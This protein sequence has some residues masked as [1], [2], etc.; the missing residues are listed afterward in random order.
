MFRVILAAVLLLL[1]QSNFLFS[2]TVNINGNTIE[3]HIDNIADFITNDNIIFHNKFPQLNIERTDDFSMPLLSFN[4]AAPADTE[5][6]IELSI[7]QKIEYYQSKIE[8]NRKIRDNRKIE[9]SNELLGTRR[10]AN[11]YRITFVP[12]EF[13]N[14]QMFIADDVTIKITMPN[15]IPKTHR[16]DIPDRILSF[17][18]DVVN[19]SQVPSIIENRKN[20]VSTDNTLSANIWYDNNIDYIRVVTKKDGIARIEISELLAIYPDWNGLSTNGLHLI[21][22]GN[23]VPI[24]VK[25]SNNQIE[26]SGQIYFLGKRAAG[27]TTW[28]DNYTDEAVFFLYYDS[29]KTPTRLEPMF[30]PATNN[31][32]ETVDID[33]HLEEDLSYFLGTVTIF[34]RTDHLEGWYFATIRR[35]K[36]NWEAQLEQFQRNFPFLSADNELL[37]IQM[38]YATLAY[39][40]H[41]GPNLVD[42]QQEYLYN[43]IINDDTLSTTKI[44]R[45]T[46]SYSG[47]KRFGNELHKGSNRIRVIN[48]VVHDS[49]F[50]LLGIDYFKLRGKAKP[51]PVNG[52][53]QFNMNKLV[54]ESRVNIHG[55][56]A[57]S[58][59]GIDTL[60][61]RFIEKNGIEGFRFT[62]SAG[63]A[64][65]SS[66]V[67]TINDTIS[68]QNASGILIGR[69]EPNKPA[70][71]SYYK[72]SAEADRIITDLNALPNGSLI[73]IACNSIFSLSYQ[74]R[75]QFAQLGA[76]EVQN[77]SSRN[78][79]VFAVKKGSSDKSEKLLTQNISGI[80]GFF[81]QSGGGSYSIAISFEQ[82]KDYVLY[83]NDS[84]A[85]EKAILSKVAKSNLRRTDLGADLIVI[86]H[87]KF[88]EPAK[89]IAEYRSEQGYRVQLAIV[90][91]IYKEFLYGRKSPHSIKEYLKF[92][93]NNWELPKPQYLLI[94]GDASW[95]GRKVIPSTRGEN[96]VPSFGQPVSDYWFGLLEGDDWEPEMI[97]GR[98]PAQQVEQ[99]Y[100]YFDKVK[101]YESI[102]TMQWM[103]RFLF[104]SGGITDMEME[105]FYGDR[106]DFFDPIMD[107]PLCADTATIAKSK[108]NAGGEEDMPRILSAINSGALWTCFLG[109]SSTQVFDM[110][111]WH[112]EYLNN[113]DR[114]GFLS[115]LSCN[116]GAFAEPLDLHSRN[117]KYILEKEK[118]FVAALGSTGVGFW[119]QDK[120]MIYFMMSTVGD[121]SLALRRAG[122]ILYYGKSRLSINNDRELVTKEIFQLLGDPVIKLRLGIEPDLFLV[123]NDLKLI[124]SSGDLLPNEN[125]DYIDIVGFLHNNGYAANDSLYLRLIHTYNGISDTLFLH[126]PSICTLEEFSFKL[127][128]FQKPG[129]HAV[130]LLAD[131]DFFDDA[132]F[133]DNSIQRTFYVYSSNLLS[134]DP[135]NHWN[136]SPNNPIFRFINPLN[137]EYEFEYI[138]NLYQIIHSNTILV[139]ESNN[140]EIKRYSTH[141]DWLPNVIL[142]DNSTYLI[143]AK[144]INTTLSTESNYSS[145][146]VHTTQKLDT[147]VIYRLDSYS[148]LSSIDLDGLKV[149]YD[150]T[151]RISETMIDFSLL[152]VNGHPKGEFL[153]WSNISLSD[154]VYL[155]HQYHRGFNIVVVPMAGENPKG[156]YRRYDTWG[157]PGDAGTS[158]A[159]VRFLRDTVRSDEYILVATSGQSYKMPTDLPNTHTGSIDSLRNVFKLYGA[160]LSDSLGYNKSYV[161]AGFKG[162][163]ESE[164]FEQINN[165][166][167][168]YVAGQLRFYGTSGKASTKLIGPAKNWNDIEV[169]GLSNNNF[170]YNIITHFI[171]PTTG[172]V[173]SQTID[174]FGNIPVENI[175]AKD[176]PFAQLEVGMSR[177]DIFADNGIYRISFKFQPAPELAIIPNST[178]A[179]PSEVLRG[180]NIVIETEVINLSL[181]TSLDTALI[182]Q[183]FID[184]SSHSN[185]LHSIITGIAANSS[186][187]FNNSI[188]SSN[189]QKTVSANVEV[190][191]NTYEQYVFNNDGSTSFRIIE[192]TTKPTAVVLIDRREIKDGYYISSTPEIEVILFDNSRLPIFD[193]RSISIRLN[194]LM[195]NAT[196]A[197]SYKFESFGTNTLE[198]ARLIVRPDTIIETDNSLFVYY[199]DASLN[200]DTLR[201]LL[202]ISRNGKIS[203]HRIAPNPMYDAAQFII[204]LEMP[205]SEGTLLIDIYN[206]TGMK[207]NSIKQNAKLGENRLLW[208]GRSADGNSLPQ[209]IYFYRIRIE[210]TIFFDPTV[211]NL[212]IIK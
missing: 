145:T 183:E 100:N 111:G 140:N 178:L 121:K 30:E 206:S 126:Y 5:L 168:A 58:I 26:S 148:E 24:Y 17:F 150:G 155:D 128:I 76:S 22:R 69:K 202:K 181:R 62:A 4:L 196:N 127:P 38:R 29:N 124:P 65:D 52:Q 119:Q 152:S 73:V 41:Q 112:V 136:I 18:G 10:G 131:S 15:A 122:D 3:I 194:G 129:E 134:I 138:F 139:K 50:G 46:Y 189:F 39:A 197:N 205:R 146:I 144:S 193:E 107:Y 187:L 40:H 92:A 204:N 182:T 102:P 82:N 25:S 179:N 166:D 13:I 117:E 91:D 101:S 7:K 120:W 93:Y 172:E 186:M 90:E 175:S 109:H 154:D 85:I 54:A 53:V 36:H 185:K 200:R 9:V 59:I 14:N 208:N 20:K 67:V 31:L 72:S 81:N 210:D 48:R 108:A 115:T 80:D 63:A 88:I 79:W 191:S 174:K 104:L 43:F 33:Y 105:L 86:A 135:Q 212:I 11:I 147:N 49:V 130:R 77:Y 34:P 60:S 95:D 201:F 177:E 45:W 75:N 61:N 35:I 55:F 153:E 28:W 157:E 37:D 97:V 173:H 57:N 199:Y 142:V 165:F 21:E 159:L 47:G 163:K 149:F 116:T 6:Q 66:L 32:I 161:F 211:G 89:E 98:I 78:G 23:D 74:L 162:A 83:F 99:V 203:N 1:T 195:L 19:L 94:I 167:T 71:F 51:F 113:K 87:S 184:L 110:D 156:T 27:D 137:E 143:N 169:I 8:N 180:N 171:N 106:F 151:L 70:I 133:A 160:L 16:R 12:A 64:R 192:D 68:R 125:D 198:K 188:E 209:G 2:S 96:Y 103:K 158:E 207:I 84:Q 44:N 176:Y 170:N 164:I 114:Y 123:S 132:N 141:I 56:N 190:N 118:G 42:P